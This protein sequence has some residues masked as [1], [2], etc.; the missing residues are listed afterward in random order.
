MRVLFTVLP[1]TGSLRPLLPVANALRAGGH[2]VAVSSSPALRSAAEQERLPFFAAGLDWDTSDPHYIEV[3][4]EAAGGLAFPPL[5]GM[6]RLVWVTNE[7]FIGTAA[8]RMLPDVIRIAREWSADLIVRQSLEYSGCTAAERLGLP[9]ASVADAAHSALDR[10]HEVVAALNGLR[11]SVGLPPDP[12]GEM[13]FRYLHLCFA[14]PR[15]DGDGALFPATAHFLRHIDPTPTAESL[16]SWLD[17]LEARPTVLV[18]MGTVFHRTTGIYEAVLEGLRDEPVNL[19]VAAGFDQDP[20]RFGPQPP[21]VRVEPYLP[22]TALLP[23]CDLFVTHGG[24]N[25]VKE[26]L[27]AGVPMVVIPISADQPYSAERCAAL[28]VGLALGPEERTASDVRRAAR[29]VLA[30]G[31]FTRRAREMQRDMSALPGPEHAVALLE[32]LHRNPVPRPLLAR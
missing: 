23:R 26:S 29:T 12:A 6:P 15:F 9:H 28:G 19:L 7:L 31:G 32:A 5:T 3:L 8:R 1:G 13:V 24:F 14:P 17:A 21:H 27:A 25:S 4:C 11:S 16:P 18:S 22:V 2:D 20:G 10:R 30:D